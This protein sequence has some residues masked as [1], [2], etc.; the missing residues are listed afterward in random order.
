MPGYTCVCGLKV[1]ALLLQEYEDSSPLVVQLLGWSGH[2]KSTYLA[3]LGFVLSRLGSVWPAYTL[4]GGTPETLQQL[5]A[6]F[7]LVREGGMPAKTAVSTVPAASGATGPVAVPQHTY[8]LRNLPD[9]GHRVVMFHDPAGQLCDDMT[10]PT[11]QLPFLTRAPVSLMFL[12][13]DDLDRD[14]FRTM[15]MLLTS[16]L[17]TLQSG[18][19]QGPEQ[20]GIVVVL[21]KADL[22]L[23]Q[24]PPEIHHYLV[25]DPLWPVL[26]ESSG[27]GASARVDAVLD[28][29]EDVRLYLEEM[30]RVEAQLREWLVEE[31]PLRTL[32]LEAKRHDIE[33]RF[34]VVSATGEEVRGQAPI[35]GTWRPHRVLDPLFWALELTR[36]HDGVLPGWQRTRRGSSNPP[37]AAE[38]EATGATF[39]LLI[40]DRR[41]FGVERKVNLERQSGDLGKVMPELKELT[42]SREGSGIRFSLAG[43]GAILFLHHRGGVERLPSSE[44]LLRPG[45]SISTDDW[46]LELRF[47]HFTSRGSN[48]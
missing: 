5:T 41:Q 33:L 6:A 43:S 20:R 24:M 3:A 35:S 21:S 40:R 48:P 38:G 2:G 9:W 44:V 12:S 32:L 4:R 27:G 16:Y 1:P 19:G 31:P 18:G 7:R 30:Y 26:L 45:E 36:G 15:D 14:D 13:A 25:S 47:G 8:L 17:H 46:Q 23:N 34:S 11:E 28:E 37:P 39:S 22:H 29:L 42:F 10:M